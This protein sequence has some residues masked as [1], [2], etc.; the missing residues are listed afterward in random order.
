MRFLFTAQGYPGVPGTSSGSGIGTYVREIALGL[1]DLGHECHAIVWSDH[2]SASESSVDGVMIHSVVRRHWPVL[3]RWWPDSRC[4]R[5]RVR[6]AAE[7]DRRHRFDWIEIQSDEGVDHRIQERYPD[8]TI[9]R[10]HT[11][12]R[13]LCQ[14]KQIAPSRLTETWLGREKR[15]LMRADKIVTHSPLHASEL[16]GLFPGIAN[17][18]I[19][20]H[21]YGSPISPRSPGQVGSRPRFLMIGTFDLRKGTDRIGAVAKA[22]AEKVGPCEFR[23]VSTSPESVLESQFGLTGPY[24]PGVSIQYLTRLTPE[25]LAEEYRN[26]TAYLHLARYESFGYP[27]IEAAAQGI[28]VVATRTGIA[29]ELLVGPLR[30]LIFEGDSPAEC[31]RALALATHSQAEFGRRIYEGYVAGFTRRIMTERYLEALAAW[32]S[33]PSV[34]KTTGVDRSPNRRVESA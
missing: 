13:Q 27:L 32:Q 33:P 19:V 22:F 18:R 8:R 34:R 20:P 30:P 5:D 7:L 3:E 25:Q 15:S 10:I 11:T 24:P 17:P 4:E 6:V 21:G 14:Y 29:P 2:G 16:V 9:L 12:L 1:T 31:V 23:L 26:A 28:P